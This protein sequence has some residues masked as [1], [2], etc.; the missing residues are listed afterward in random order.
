MSDTV[1]VVSFIEPGSPEW[2][3][4]FRQLHAYWVAYQAGDDE[5]SEALGRE[6]VQDCANNPALTAVIVNVSA[7][8]LV[9]AL[10]AGRPDADVAA[11]LNVLGGACEQAW[12]LRLVK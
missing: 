12:P 3:A 5:R 4:G 8:A 6:I 10:K 9:A 11:M 7:Q 1:V 2:R